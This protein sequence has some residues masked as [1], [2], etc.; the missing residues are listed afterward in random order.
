METC[1]RMEIRRWVHKAIGFFMKEGR[2]KTLAQ[3]SDPRGP[4][5]Y[6]SRYV[7]ALNTGGDLLA[8][9]FLKQLQGKNIFEL[10]DSE[11]K[12]FIQ[13]LLGTAKKRGYGYIDYRWQVPDSK[14]EL[15][16]TLFF[17]RVDGMI[18]CGGF[19]SNKESPLEAI[20]KCF[21]PYGPA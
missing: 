8:H 7:F 17:E 14:E 3:I 5:I 10:R 20:Y 1:E 13:K 15:P 16:K 19:Y 11:G 4:F 2:E 6:G 12:G 21:R 9:P 18:L